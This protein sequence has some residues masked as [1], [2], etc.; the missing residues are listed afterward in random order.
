[1]NKL[2][3]L[4]LF[5]M[6]VSISACADTTPAAPSTTVAPAVTAPAPAAPVKQKVKASK[7]VAFRAAK[8]LKEAV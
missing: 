8:E 3:V 6:A 4:A 5:G 2:L 7:K 1:M